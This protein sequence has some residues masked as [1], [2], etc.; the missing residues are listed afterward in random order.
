VRSAENPDLRL[1]IA[2]CGFGVA[3]K[4]FGV[5]E[6]ETSYR[7]T[8]FLLS[9]FLFAPARNSSAGVCVSLKLCFI[10]AAFPSSLPF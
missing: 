10:E 1:P 3:A 4:T 9:I 6:W 5:R 7:L 8:F 2:D